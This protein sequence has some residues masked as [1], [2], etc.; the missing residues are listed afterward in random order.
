MFNPLAIYVVNTNYPIT[1]AFVDRNGVPIQPTT[2]T[3]WAIDPNGTVIQLTVD[4]NPSTGVFNS[5]WEPNIGGSWTLTA[6]GVSPDIHAPDQVIYVQP[7][8]AP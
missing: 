6:K 8:L 1:F 5:H 4:S 7:S 3:I 2:V